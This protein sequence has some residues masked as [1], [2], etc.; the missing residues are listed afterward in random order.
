MNLEIDIKSYIDNVA[1]PISLDEIIPE[2][3]AMHGSG[4]Q[5]TG[6]NNHR[7]GR[8]A[9]VLVGA[10]AV[11]VAAVSA[12]VV[13]ELFQADEAVLATGATD[14]LPVDLAAGAWEN[15]GDPNASFAPANVV[16]TLGTESAASQILVSAVTETTDGYIAVGREQ[17]GFFA[18]A[19]IWSTSDGQLWDRVAVDSP[20]LGEFGGKRGDWS[21]TGF[22]MADVATNGDT[23]VAVGDELGDNISPTAWTSNRN[24]EWQRIALPVQRSGL[25]SATNVVSTPTGFLAFGYHDPGSRDGS[26]NQTLAWVSPDGVNWSRVPDPGFEA[27]DLINDIET[28]NDRVIAIGT[29][30]GFSSRQAAAW[31]SNDSQTWTKATVPAAPTDRPVTQ[32]VEVA[33]GP[34]GLFAIGHQATNGDPSFSQ[35]REDGPRTLGNQQDIMIW[36]SPDGTEWKQAGELRSPGQLTVKPTITDGP[37]GYLVSFTTIT[38]N[39]IEASSWLIFNGSQLHQIDH[40]AGRSLDVTASFPDHYVAITSPLIGGNS[41]RS[42]EPA[43]PLEVWQLRFTG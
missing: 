32:M 43:P 5:D 35:E 29:S 19:A 39:T 12:I 8:V 7:P 38:E 27:G 25:T 14:Q 3:Q 17:V 18:V 22:S 24:G 16:D 21:P 34:D 20:A 13:T 6:G 15:I 4:H 9:V 2:G 11:I 40:P 1:P 37:G 41:T 31:V 23:I 26:E 42:P 28:L 33:I 30:G 10:A 36:S